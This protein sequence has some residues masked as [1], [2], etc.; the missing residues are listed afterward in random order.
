MDVENSSK[1]GFEDPLLQKAKLALSEGEELPISFLQI[2]F[3]IGCR[4]ALRLYD[5]IRINPEKRY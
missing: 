2:R 5:A 4:R 3:K 1:T